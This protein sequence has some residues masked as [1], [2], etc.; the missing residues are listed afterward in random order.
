MF[1]KNKGQSIMDKFYGYSTMSKTSNVEDILYIFD[2]SNEDMDKE[3]VDGLE[4]IGH[5]K[6]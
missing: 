2:S 4:I 1:P 6:E 5:D 3:I